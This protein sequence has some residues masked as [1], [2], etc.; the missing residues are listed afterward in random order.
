[1]STQ[2]H[3]SSRDPAQARSL[4]RGL[5]HWLSRYVW[6]TRASPVPG[7]DGRG[8]RGGPSSTPPPPA[9]PERGERAAASTEPGYPRWDWAWE[10]AEGL[11]LSTTQTLLLLRLAWH[12]DRVSGECY[13][14][15]KTLAAYTSI[16]P[17]SV[18]REL[19]RLKALGLV[20]EVK[21][22]R[23]GR[24]KVEYRVTGAPQWD[25]SLTLRAL[26]GDRE[27]LYPLE[28]AGSPG[29]GASRPTHLNK[30]LNK[31]QEREP[32]HAHEAN[33]VRS[34]E[35]F[36]STYPEV[37]AELEAEYAGATFD[38]QDEVEAALGHGA[39]K[40]WPRTDLYVRRWLEREATPREGGR[41]LRRAEVETDWRKDFMEG[42][43]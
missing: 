4:T 19:T 26:G 29:E 17:R 11:D 7:E 21:R 9:P 20:T 15:H 14:G 40:K 33:G 30:A 8:A 16:H 34:L 43:F 3:S 12:A 31:A 18:R 1:M 27:S 37:L 41:S 23:G 6:G 39:A 5:R 25:A 10:V 42:T 38:V 28:G 2:H 13:P 36:K 22:Y 35:D 32:T 24:H